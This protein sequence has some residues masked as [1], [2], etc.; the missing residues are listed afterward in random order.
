MRYTRVIA[1]VALL[2]I[3]TACTRDTP[4][5]NPTPH[6]TR[7]G[8]VVVIAGNG[9][10]GSAMSGRWALRSPIIPVGA[11]AAAPDGTLYL[12]V[13]QS[14][15]NASV[16]IARIATDGRLSLV[17][18]PIEWH[19]AD[20]VVVGARNLW[21]LGTG[22]EPS[23]IRYSMSGAEEVR[24]LSLRTRRDGPTLIDERDDPSS[25][26]AQRSERERWLSGEHHPA[27]AAVRTDG[28]PVVALRSGE[29]FTVPSPGKIRRWRPQGYAAALDD[30]M[31][32]G[33][34]VDVFTRA[35]HALV[36][37]GDGLTVLTSAGVIAIPVR[38]RVKGVPIDYPERPGYGITW[39]GG[40]KTADGTLVLATQANPPAASVLVKV[41][42][43]GRV[44]RL[45]PDWPA[46]C[47]GGPASLASGQPGT[48]LIGLAVR[49]KDGVI[50]ADTAC[51]RLY[52]I[53]STR[54]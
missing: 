4:S 48:D 13:R 19:R 35:V 20:K 23:L 18:P 10:S 6:P 17:G 52:E 44:S 33:G 51:R 49:P 3:V 26:D 38:G 22:P 54:P 12:P 53:R 2:A 21:I 8:Q 39:A 45:E 50:A 46:T 36:A 29:L 30:L 41:L 14:G 40:G 37:D 31:R 43:D 32:R 11:L 5:F 27:A 24:Y 1:P 25:E 7:P 9:E 28:T 42:P 47:T 34:K 16:R 15:E